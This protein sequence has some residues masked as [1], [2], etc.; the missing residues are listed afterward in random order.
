ME[1]RREGLVGRGSRWM[2]LSRENGGSGRIPTPLNVE[3]T[4][5]SF[6]LL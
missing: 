2:S 1:D 6:K 4:P 3:F 5:I